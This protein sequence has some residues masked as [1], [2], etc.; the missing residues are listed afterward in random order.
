MPI[1]SA[2]VRRNRVHRQRISLHGAIAKG[3]RQW[4]ISKIKAVSKAAKA[5]SRNQAKAAKAVKAANRNQDKVAKA[6]KA[7]N[8]NQDKVANRVA[9]AA[10]VANRV[11]AANPASSARP[12]M[13]RVFSAVPMLRELIER[14]SR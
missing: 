13:G 3:C 12:L 4:L 9:R 10:R 2:L 8:R 14:R 5:D 7:A 6:V 11:E 1:L